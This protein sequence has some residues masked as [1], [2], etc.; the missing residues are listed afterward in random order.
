MNNHRYQVRVSRPAQIDYYQI[1]D[2]LIERSPRAAE[3]FEEKLD[4]LLERLENSPFF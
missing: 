4:K 2:Y 3:N 1:I